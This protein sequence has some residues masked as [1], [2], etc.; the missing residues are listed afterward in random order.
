MSQILITG[1]SSGGASDDCTALKSDIPKGLK[2]VT[3]DS[4]DE[5]IEGTLELTG[6]T[7]ADDVLEGKTFYNTD[8]HKKET[9]TLKLTGNAQT[10]HVLSG[11]TFYS[12]DP[13]NKL[14]GTMTVNSILS[15]ELAGVSGRQI[16]LQ[17]RNPTSAIGKPFSGIFVNYSTSGYPGKDGTR[18]YTG[19]GNNSASGGISQ[20]WV[21]LPTLG[22]T[23]YFSAYAYAQ[24]SAGDLYSPEFRAVGT[25][26]GVITNTYTSSQNVTV[27]AGY[28]LV[29]IFCVGGGAGGQGGGTGSSNYPG[30]SGDGGS[31]GYTNTVYNIVVSAGQILNCI[32]GAGGAGGV[33]GTSSVDDQ[34]E[35]GGCGGASTVYSNGNALCIANGG[36]NN[37]GGSG[38]GCGRGS[39]TP[40]TYIGGNGGSNG[41]DGYLEYANGLGQGGK[42]QGFT[43]TAFKEN[44]GTIYSGGGAGGSMA[45][46][47]GARASGGNYGGGVGGMG[48][49]RSGGS[50][51]EPVW[52]GPDS[53]TAGAASSGGGGGG[54]GGGR[55]TS[56]GGR[57]ADGSAGGSGIILIR[58][59]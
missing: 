5:V 30:D 21:T 31:G 11:Q 27:P 56:G 40:N 58:F 10:N 7:N 23:Y 9:G 22:T 12:T 53:G 37:N 45:Y 47:Y 33:R 49:W 18:I 1:G 59:K 29:D 39:Y 32:V 28:T 13:K 54:G 55:R 52:S 51:D 46:T 42:G 2:A 50:S 36:C 41:S 35:Y 16:L 44:W 38:G 34:G 26:G 24:T 57:G 8:V 4:D 14:T 15:F 25:T 48:I 19:F 3:K 43:T 17:W 6:S 20:V